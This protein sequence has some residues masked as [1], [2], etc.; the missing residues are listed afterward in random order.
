MLVD[1]FF[2][3]LEIRVDCERAHHRTVCHYLS[4]NLWHAFSDLISLFTC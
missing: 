2:V 1:A 3:T 4:L